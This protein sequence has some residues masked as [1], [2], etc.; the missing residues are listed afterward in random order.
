M[1]G[2]PDAERVLPV[3]DERRAEWRAKREAGEVA[4]DA[5]MP[6]EGELEEH[7]KYYVPQPIPE[8][9]VAKAPESIREPQA[10]RPGLR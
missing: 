2:R 4:L 10:P 3:L 5:L 9:A 8:D 7:W 1:G 6:I